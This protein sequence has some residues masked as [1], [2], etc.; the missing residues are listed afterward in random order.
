MTLV[1]SVHHHSGRGFQNK[2]LTTCWIVPWLLRSGPLY[3]RWWCAESVNI[4]PCRMTGVTLHKN[5]RSDFT[6]G[7]IP[8]QGGRRTLVVALV[9]VG[10][11]TLA[12]TV[13]AGSTTLV[14]AVVVGRAEAQQVLDRENHHARLFCELRQEGGGAST[15]T[16]SHPHTLTPCHPHTPTH[17][18]S[19]PHTHTRMKLL[20]VNK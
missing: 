1:V 8:R 19:H 3:L 12:V 2:A 9:V 18:P 4:T 20:A 17:T 16:P 13:V 6:R 11:T 15:L 14:V 5:D 7:C 10:S